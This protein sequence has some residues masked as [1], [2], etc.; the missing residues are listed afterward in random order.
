MFRADLDRLCIC[1]WHIFTSYA[2]LFQLLIAWVWGWVGASPNVCVITARFLPCGI[3]RQNLT[4]FP[5]ELKYYYIST[6]QATKKLVLS[7]G[8]VADSTTRRIHAKSHANIVNVRGQ[9]RRRQSEY[10]KINCSSCS[11]AGYFCFPRFSP[12]TTPMM[13]LAP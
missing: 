1:V 11:P 13:G 8:A 6:V 5:S 12:A 2:V 9:G 4:C 7:P 10:T 3:V